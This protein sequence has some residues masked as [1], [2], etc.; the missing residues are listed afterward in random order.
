[1]CSCG[2]DG[3]VFDLK[4]TSA[5]LKANLLTGFMVAAEDVEEVP[6]L[7]SNSVI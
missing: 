4:R 6:P 2:S 3:M 5:G 7:S 1:M